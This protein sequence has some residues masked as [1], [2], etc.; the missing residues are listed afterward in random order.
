[1]G[2]TFRVHGPWLWSRSSRPARCPAGPA[3]PSRRLLQGQDVRI[4]IGSGEGSG[5][6]ILGR[7]TAR[8]I[9]KHIA[10]NPTFIAQ[11]MPQPESIAAANHL[12]N[13]AEKDG[14]T[15]APAR[16]ACSAAP[17]RSPTSASTSAS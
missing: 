16:R 7:I 9:G 13:V 1:M 15:W 6:D 3:P 2:Q 12:Y 14:L 4:I 8:H 10:G 17:F 5:V 11:N